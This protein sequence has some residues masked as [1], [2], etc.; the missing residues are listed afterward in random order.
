M[1]SRSLLT[2]LFILCRSVVA[3]AEDSVPHATIRNLNSTARCEENTY[4]TYNDDGSVHVAVKDVIVSRASEQPFA[5]CLIHGDV[6]VPAG[7]AITPAQFADAEFVTHHE[8]IG[9]Q[10][11]G[12]F[13]LDVNDATSNS[14]AMSDRRQEHNEDA[15]LILKNAI[16][17]FSACGSES[18]LPLRITVEAMINYRLDDTSSVSS[19]IDAIRFPSLRITPIQCREDSL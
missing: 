18:V 15:T 7:F 10:S 9:D 19:R 4:V 8:K 16:P 3:S 5:K 13:R 12:R 17:I 14:S 11:G 1:S 6:V 2:L